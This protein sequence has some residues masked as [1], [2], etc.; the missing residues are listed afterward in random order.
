[1]EQKEKTNN[2]YQEVVSFGEI[3][4][5][6]WTQFITVIGIV[7]VVLSFAFSFMPETSYR[8]ISYVIEIL[9]WTFGIPRP[10]HRSLM[11]VRLKDEAPRTKLAKVKKNFR[12]GPEIWVI[13]KDQR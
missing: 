2:E 5:D 1:M 8:M 13:K 10:N 12:E 3:L 7:I 9:Y 11:D 4:C 6:T